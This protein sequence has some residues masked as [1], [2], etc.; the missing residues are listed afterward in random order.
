[1]K[2]DIPKITQSN[3]P[4]TIQKYL[5]DY[6]I[7]L[8]NKINQYTT[9]LMLQLTSC[10]STLPRLEIADQRLKKFVRLHHLDLLRK[11]NY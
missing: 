8:E 6:L 2:D 1:M 7:L 10:S 3:E 5:E 4:K 11:I 9:E